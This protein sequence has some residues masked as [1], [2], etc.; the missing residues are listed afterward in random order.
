M[1]RIIFGILAFSLI[2][3]PMSFA[4][5]DGLSLN[6]TLRLAYK[7]N[8]EMNQARQEIEASK[9]RHI[10]AEALPNPEAELSV[11]GLKAKRQIAD[12]GSEKVSRRGSLDTFSIKQP[13]DPLGTRFLR[14]RIASDEVKI[15][16]SDLNFLWGGI[17]KNIVS[18]YAEILTEEKAKEIAQS[19]LTATRQ[20][21]TSVET[22]FQSGSSLQSDVIRANIEVS[23]AEND[24]LVSDKNL[25]LSKG[26]MNLSLGRTV[27]SV[28]SLS[29]S[30]NYE[31]LKYQYQTV[32]TDAYTNRAD[33]LSETTRLSAREKSVQKSILKTFLPEMSIGV[34]RSTQDFDND[35]SLLLQASYPLWGFNLGE[36]KEAQAEKEKQKIRLESLKREVGLDVYQ[37]F[38][39]AE[40]AD[41]QVLLQQKALDEANELLR[42]ISIQYEGGKIQFLTYLENIK[43]IKETRL[44]YFVALKEYKEKVAELERVIQATPIPEGEKS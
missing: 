5:E 4:A 22:K 26:R 35:T 3:S 1:S 7:Y 6:E 19:N 32:L 25:K 43:T 9:G 42:Q 23:R 30:L 18:L 2:L 12:D 11:G 29:D 33:L 21:F 13:L 14:G 41:K 16:Q 36:V 40:L 17:R 15:A 38:I 27:D 34:E 39:E 37:A 10:Q 44:A 31:A 28:F 24:F 8:P 20:F